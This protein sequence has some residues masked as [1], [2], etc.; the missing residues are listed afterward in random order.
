MDAQK[1]RARL[2][3][4][5]CTLKLY[6]VNELL[7]KQEGLHNKQIYVEGILNF[8]FEDI[9]LLHWPSSERENQSVWVEQGEGVFCFNEK[10]LKSLHARKIVCL[11]KIESMK[12]EWGY[13]HMGLWSV[14]IIPREI[15]YYKKWYEANGN[16]E[17]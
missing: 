2:K 6:S 1:A 12:S 17:T 14:Q 13:G 7:S 5:R 9:S 16:N 3:G 4:V 8:E 15:V 10:K 11:G